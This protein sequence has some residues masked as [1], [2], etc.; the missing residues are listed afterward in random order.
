MTACGASVEDLVVH[1]A[2]LLVNVVIGLGTCGLSS[3]AVFSDY[4]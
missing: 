2:K 1:V 3:K 4:T